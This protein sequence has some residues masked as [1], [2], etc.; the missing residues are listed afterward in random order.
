MWFVCVLVLGLLHS[1]ASLHHNEKRSSSSSSVSLPWNE[2]RHRRAKDDGSCE[3]EIHC[4]GGG[5]GDGQRS[6]ASGVVRLPIRGQRGPPGAPG[7]KGEKGHSETG[8]RSGLL[9]YQV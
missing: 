2:R 1:T 6:S 3:L 8:G 4:A 9:F 7:A 5:R